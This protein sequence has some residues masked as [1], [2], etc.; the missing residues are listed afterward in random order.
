[1]VARSRPV[2][3]NAVRG[4]SNNLL[5]KRWMT[6]CVLALRTGGW[7]NA[8]IIT[9]NHRSDIT[10]AGDIGIEC[11]DEQDWRNLAAHIGQASRDAEARDLPTYV[12]WRKRRGKADAMEGYCVM[13]ARDFWAER[14]RMEEL[15][16]IELEYSNLLERMRA[17]AGAVR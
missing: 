13:R 6:A 9:S 4:R 16:Q 8:E 17:Q 10:G 2:S 5:G 15:E 1:M 3:I 7:P 12:V 11:K 14:Q